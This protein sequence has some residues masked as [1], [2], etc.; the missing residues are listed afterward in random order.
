MVLRILK[1]QI[2]KK[3]V[4]LFCRLILVLLTA[5]TLYSYLT[6]LLAFTPPVK[7]GPYSSFPPVIIPPPPTPSEIENMPLDQSVEIINYMTL[8]DSADLLIQISPNISARIFENLSKVRAVSII[9]RIIEN[10]H[11]GYIAEMFNEMSP[12]EIPGI[13]HELE[14]QNTI[15]VFE[16]MAEKNVTKAAWR[17]EETIK[18]SILKGELEYFSETIIEKINHSSLGVLLE[19]I[20]WLPTSPSTV[21]SYSTV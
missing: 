6:A 13:S 1:S 10:G 12:N 19:E 16:K 21:A 8:S 17:L 3:S 9:Q 11:L 20:A 7:Q 5:F 2:S 18:E 15:Q 4:K 14:P